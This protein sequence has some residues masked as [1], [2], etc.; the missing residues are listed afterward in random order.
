MMADVMLARWPE[1]RDDGSRMALEGLAVL[2]LVDGDSDPPPVRGCLE[3]WVRIPGDE[4]DLRA[5]VAALEARSHAHVAPPHIDKEG[6]LTYGG[7]ITMLRAD[8]VDLAR[9]LISRF[10]DVVG[11]GELP[12]QPGTELRSVVSQLRA[13]LRDL[14]LTLRRVRRRGYRLQ[15][16]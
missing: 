4:R 16:A 9:T 13:Q 5:R 12:A 3:D 8:T 10:G 7:R 14:G 2:Y 1:D 11:D 15:A 6:R